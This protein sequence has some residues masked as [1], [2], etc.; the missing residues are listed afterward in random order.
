[1]WNSSRIP[2]HGFK[3]PEI[4]TPEF[5][6]KMMKSYLGKGVSYHNLPSIFKYLDNLISK[7][8]SLA[9]IVLILCRRI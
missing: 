8:P 1:M 7:I 2:R 6:I 5:V 3:A 4:T 9:Q